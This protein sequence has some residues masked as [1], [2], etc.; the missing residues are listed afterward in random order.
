[1]GPFLNRAFRPVE[2]RSG[3]HFNLKTQKF[4]IIKHF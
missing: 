1:M 3:I 4:R 2:S